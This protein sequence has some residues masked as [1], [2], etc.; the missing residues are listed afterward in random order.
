VQVPAWQVSVPLQRL[1]SL[2]GV[3]LV[4]G[5]VWQPVA[6]LQVS[7][8]HALPSLQVSDAPAVQVPAWQVSAP[9]QRLLSLHAVP[10]ASGGFWQTPAVQTSEVHGLPSVQS[11][12]LEQGRQ[13]AIGTLLQPVP[14]LQMSVVQLLL[15][16]QLRA[17]PAVQVPAWQ[18]S[19]PLQRLLSSHPVPLATG[20]FWQ[21]P[22]LQTLEV[23]ELPS[24]QS[25]PLEQGRQPAIGW[26]LQ[27]VLG[28]QVSVVQAL[29]SLQV[30]AV[31]AV[32]V[33]AWQASLPLQRLPSS[34]GVPLATGAVWQP[35]AG[36]Q[37]SVVQTLP[38]LQVRGVPAV[39]VAA[40]QVSAPLQ[41]LLS[42]H[43][44][45][46]VTGIVWQPVAG[47]Q[48]S[49]VHTLPSLQVRG[50]PAVQVPA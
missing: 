30:S 41:R 7:V 31:P 32:Q 21:T 40:W 13:P 19:L 37:L 36:L 45:P 20:G 12:P 17:E 48:L 27:P 8:V 33:P 44:V 15:S 1:L 42:L 2:H 24:A 26:V 18:V 49:V 38:S 11:L 47:L 14:G 16:L 39:Q 28:L 5:A 43:G 22:A 29:P 3:P 35:V 9:L 34:H 6:G 23:H 46:L 10:L 25:L 50:V 4:M